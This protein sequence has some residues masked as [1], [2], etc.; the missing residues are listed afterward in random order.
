MTPG[1]LALLCIGV[2]LALMVVAALAP[3]AR[4]V[5]FVTGL[6]FVCLA[7]GVLNWDRSGGH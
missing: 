4:E 5:A 3:P 7:G 2:A 6:F 1:R